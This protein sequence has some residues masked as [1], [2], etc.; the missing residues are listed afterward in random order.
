MRGGLRVLLVASL[1]ACGGNPIVPPPPV[2]QVAG[3]YALQ[4]ITGQDLPWTLAEGST[5]K[6]EYI[7]GRVTLA[8]N[9]TFER[10]V[11]R[12]FT[13]HGTATEDTMR[14]SGT[15]TKT[16]SGAVTLRFSF[17]LATP[18][19][20]QVVEDTLSVFFSGDAWTFVK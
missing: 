17:A 7:G 14:Q 16:D 6:T 9:L 3:T 18:N 20:G 5:S 8:E 2:V 1:T 15:Y 11:F 10:M 4:T 19:A 12:R 13:S